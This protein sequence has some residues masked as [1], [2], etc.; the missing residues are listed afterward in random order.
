MLE[1]DGTESSK[2]KG[3]SSEAE[4]SKVRAVKLK[5]QRCTMIACR[6]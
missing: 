2:L 5:A 1:G 3:E 6:V 4:G